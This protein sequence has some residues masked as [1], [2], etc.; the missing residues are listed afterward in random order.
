MRGAGAFGIRC[1]ELARSRESDWLSLVKILIRRHSS[2]QTWAPLPALSPC[3]LR[4]WARTASAMRKSMMTISCCCSTATT[5]TTGWCRHRSQR[6]CRDG[7]GRLRLERR[8]AG[9]CG[10]GGTGGGAHMR[11]EPYEHLLQ[12]SCCLS[13]TAVSS[14]VLAVYIDLGWS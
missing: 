3:P 10:G 6:P 4:T 12:S 13:Q 11:T 2:S 14:L 1:G 7:R 9:L 5:T 8:S